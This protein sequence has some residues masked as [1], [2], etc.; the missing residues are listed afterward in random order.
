MT[1]TPVVLVGVYYRKHHLSPLPQDI[2]TPAASATQ[3]K[4]QATHHLPVSTSSPPPPP[5]SPIAEPPR[6][7]PTSTCVSGYHAYLWSFLPSSRQ[8]DLHGPTDGNNTPNSS[9]SKAL[10]GALQLSTRC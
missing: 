8:G 7:E 5:G 2:R 9:S 3:P 1:A 4:T 10:I 6:G